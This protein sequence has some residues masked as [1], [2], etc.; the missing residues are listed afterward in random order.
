MSPKIGKYQKHAANIY[1]NFCSQPLYRFKDT[2]N[3]EK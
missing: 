3:T 1:F 2:V